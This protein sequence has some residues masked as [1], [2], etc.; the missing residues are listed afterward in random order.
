MQLS[1]RDL[2]LKFL[3]KEKQVK[4]MTKRQSTGIYKSGFISAVGHLRAK[5]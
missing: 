4:K 2:T 5:V 3:F 1:H